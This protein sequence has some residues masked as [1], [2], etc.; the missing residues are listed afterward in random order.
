[1]LADHRPPPTTPSGGAGGTGG[2]G[3]TGGGVQGWRTLPG[4]GELILVV[5]D[6]ENLRNA[7]TRMLKSLGFATLTAANGIEAL[8][9]IENSSAA[10]DALLIDVVMPQLGGVE[11][12]ER[13]ASRG[14]H[15]A[16]IYMTGY[17][18]P[19]HLARV[20]ESPTTPLL[21]KPFTLHALVLV[22]RDIL[23]RPP[24]QSHGL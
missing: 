24:P 1:M 19:A 23:D 12:V 18:D 21:K 2:T 10:I 3:G 13:L 5:D 6:D 9:L 17:D 11:L 7:L 15:P 8:A 4:R 22:L 20:P 16:V 14:I